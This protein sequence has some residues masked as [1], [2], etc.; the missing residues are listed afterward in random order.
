MSAARVAKAFR[1]DPVTVYGEQDAS[2]WL[3]RVAAYKVIQKDEK[4]QADASKRK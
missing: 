4:A 3:V 2:R 1:L